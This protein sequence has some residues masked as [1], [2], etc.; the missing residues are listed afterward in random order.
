MRLPVAL[1]TAHAQSAGGAGAGA[2][3]EG[4][5]VLVVDDDLDGLELAR[6]ILAGAGA[7]V[8]A[9]ASASAAPETLSTWQADV[10]P[11]DIEMPGED[12]YMLLRQLRAAGHRAPAV[13][14]TAYGRGEDKKRALAAGFDLHL[15]KP[16][17]PAALTSAIAKVAPRRA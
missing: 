13:A 4:R 17:D 7:D 8:R 1:A 16:V 14:L 12:G 5:R 2:S 10:L 11:L 15:A 9:C 3:L 6:V